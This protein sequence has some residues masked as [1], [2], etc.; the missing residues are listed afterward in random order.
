LNYTSKDRTLALAGI[1]QAARLVH[2]IARKGMCDQGSFTTSIASIFALDAHSPEAVYGGAGNLTLGLRS[3]L[4]QLGG[5]Q[6]SENA[7]QQRDIEAMKYAVG[8]MVL[9]RKFIKDTALVTK[10]SKGIQDATTQLQHFTM[11][12]ENVIANLANLYSET[13][14]GLKPRIIV[15]GDPNHLSNP[16]NI[17]KIR[18]LLLAA[19]RS[20]VLWRQCGGNRWQLFFQRQ[21]I[22]EDAKRILAGHFSSS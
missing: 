22:L 17:N 11:V 8:A 21:P 13:L 9:E 6:Y 4:V 3:L 7:S 20:A 5:S 19:V 10:V 12:H 18:A 14:S 1:L 15:N 2:Q 16:S